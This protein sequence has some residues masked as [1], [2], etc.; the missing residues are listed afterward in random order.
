MS[1]PSLIK[2]QFTPG[3]DIVVTRMVF[4]FAFVINCGGG[5]CFCC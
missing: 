3:N 2:L 4:F 5:S 1:V